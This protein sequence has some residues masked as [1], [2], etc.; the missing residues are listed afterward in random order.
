MF[1][2]FTV[3]GK[4]QDMETWIC[5]KFYSFANGKGQEVRPHTIIGP[6]EISQRCRD[7]IHAQTCATNY[8]TKLCG[9]EG[10][11]KFLPNILF[12]LVK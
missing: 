1:G 2:W 4:G 6:N 11:H 8:C 10:T 3:F 12:Y 9:N 7:L 5:K